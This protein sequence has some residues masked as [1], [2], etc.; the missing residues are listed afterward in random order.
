M[1]FPRT[2]PTNVG[3]G[4]QRKRST[5]S[6]KAAPTLRRLRFSPVVVYEWK[7]QV[8]RLRQSMPLQPTSEYAQRPDRTVPQQY[9]LRHSLPKKTRF[10]A[11]N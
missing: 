11:Y 4:S 8:K 2:G 6:P 3:V 9:E 7:Q 10:G 5:R 1:G